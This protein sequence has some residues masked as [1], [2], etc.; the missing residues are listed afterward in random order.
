VQWDVHVALDEIAELG[1]QIY[2]A[3]E[4]IVTELVL[5]VVPNDVRGG[6]G[7]TDDG[8]DILGDRVVEPA[9]KALV[10]NLPFAIAALGRGWWGSEMIAEAKFADER[11]EESAPLGIVGLGELKDNGNVGFYVHGQRKEE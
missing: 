8:E 9:E 7:H 5:D 2:G 1:L 4:L 10:H 11:V 3:V 6:L